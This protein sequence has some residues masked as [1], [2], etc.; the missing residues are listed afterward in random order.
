MK[1][2]E[3]LVICLA[4][5]AIL[6]SNYVVAYA[7][8]RIIFGI[9]CS[10]FVAKHSVSGRSIKEFCSKGVKK[11][12]LF[13]YAVSSALELRIQRHYPRKNMGYVL[14]IFIMI[15]FII[16]VLPYLILFIKLP[17][18]EVIDPIVVTIALLVVAIHISS[19]YFAI[20]TALGLYK[21]GN[22]S[23]NI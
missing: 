12:F 14:F 2:G 5:I 23:Q 16:G 9:A 4:I 7:S 8:S 1:S 6:G 18:M 17:E 3:P 20:D 22:K 11:R 21:F 15:E 13:R 10:Y 19:I